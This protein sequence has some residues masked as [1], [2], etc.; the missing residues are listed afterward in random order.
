MKKFFSLITVLLLLTITVTAC[1]SNST[2]DTGDAKEKTN[3][4]SEDV[5]VL[6]V[7]WGNEMHTGIMY[8]PF[9]AP[10]LFE[11]ESIR[12]NPISDSQ[13]ELQKDGKTIA[14]LKQV[15]TKGG[16]EVATL[17]GQKHLD[18]GYTSSTAMLTAYDT[19]TELSILCPIQADGVAI[20]A[21]K[22]VPYNTFDEFVKYA[23]ESKQPI[24]AGYH[25]AVSS[26]RVVLEYAMKDAGLKVTEDPGDVEADVLLV[27]LKG[28]QNLVPS[29]SSGQVELW[30]GPAPNPQNAESTGVGKIIATL[31]DLPEGKWSNFPCCVFSARNE[32]IEK[33]PEVFEALMTVTTYTAD[34]ANENQEKTGELLADTIGVEKDILPKSLI[35]YST[36]P[37]DRFVEG[38]KVY[39]EAMTDM[40]KF[41]GRL[42][43]NTF[44]EAK[45]DIFKFDIVNKV[46]S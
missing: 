20:A 39:Y 1:G 10:E 9:I 29:L 6:N 7:S 35:K 8:L 17:M 3:S 11:D 45:D 13:G 24:K 34:Y 18:I 46:R 5:P 33:Y 37:T 36:E 40:G 21:A 14:I 41:E 28:V 15:V 2:K 22:D 31:N 44:E 19:G 25:S 27:D 32:V 42:K 26:P 23:K 4:S 30:A 12:I 38:M 43:D 16:S